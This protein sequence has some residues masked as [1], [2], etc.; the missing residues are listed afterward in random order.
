MEVGH[1]TDVV[2]ALH[3]A[4]A[5]GLDRG[6]AVAEV[7]VEG[8]VLPVEDHEV[9]ERREVGGERVGRRGRLQHRLHELVAGSVLALGDRPDRLLVVDVEVVWLRET[10]ELDAV[11]G[12]F[13]AGAVV[14]VALVRLWTLAFGEILGVL[15]VGVGVPALECARADARRRM[16]ARTFGPAQ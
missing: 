2:R 6:G 8:V 3:R 11:R 9:R 13:G 7:V 5:A 1:G 14:V 4:V 12:E 16:L 15:G 10:G